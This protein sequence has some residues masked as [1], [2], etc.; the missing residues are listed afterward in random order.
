M[1]AVILCLG[2]M[3]V[4]AEESTD[5][6]ALQKAK[7]LEA[8]GLL[9]DAVTAEELCARE[10]ITR[11]EMA[12]VMVKMSGIDNS[13]AADTTVYFKDVEDGSQYAA[14]IAAALQLGIINGNGDY[15]F[16]PD[17]FVSYE[18]LAKM[19]VATLGYD[20]QAQLMGGFPTG[21]MQMA[22]K[23]G[24]KSIATAVKEEAVSGGFAADFL[25]EM[26]DTD[27]SYV[28]GVGS[29]VVY[30]TTE[31]KTL[32]TENLKI[33]T[34]E[35]ILT[36]N[37]NSD[38]YGTPTLDEG[39]VAINEVTYNYSGESSEMLGMSVKAYYKEERGVGIKDVI[40]IEPSNDNK[41]LI[42][43]AE[44]ASYLGGAF[45]YFDESDRKKTVSVDSGAA[46]VYNGR[47]ITTAGFDMKKLVPE[48]GQ[49]KLIDNGLGSGYNVIVVS[50]Y[51][52]VVVDTV[53][54]YQGIIYD[55]YLATRN[56]VLGKD[57]Y[58][59]LRC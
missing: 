33:Y 53:D 47:A 49:I 5:I 30:T 15:T 27:V 51:T 35:G 18:A 42:I 43:D 46:I 40:C 1:F 14:D 26:L 17:E 58:E 31:G 2:A 41:I 4:F 29:D 11:D 39:E 50:A 21:Y 52:N 37:K 22:S 6:V 12:S 34:A 36:G 54:V 55:K 3:P 19:A 7:T 8:L 44:D 28:S 9:P 20:T 48:E 10:G 23:I 56:I 32:L 16:C 57:N 59:I 24:L 45:A 38:L 13:A 25:Y